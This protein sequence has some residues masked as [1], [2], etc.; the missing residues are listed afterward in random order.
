MVPPDSMPLR[1]GS[2]VQTGVVFRSAQC[3]L[4]VASAVAKL[5]A[6]DGQMKLGET[7]TPDRRFWRPSAALLNDAFEYEFIHKMG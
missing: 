4:V 1:R 5:V 7:R 3:C 2:A 6:M